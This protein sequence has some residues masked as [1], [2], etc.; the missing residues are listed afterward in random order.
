MRFGPRSALIWVKKSD[1]I[2]FRDIFAGQITTATAE[3]T[4]AA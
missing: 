3:G 2:L 1:A 4:G